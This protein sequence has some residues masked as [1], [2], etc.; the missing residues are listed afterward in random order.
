MAY[1][2]ETISPRFW[3]GT[4]SQKRLQEVLNGRAS[5]GAKLAWTITDARRKW[6]FFKRDTH[7]LIFER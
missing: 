3:T 5:S 7:F 6:L 4:L 2:V 1:E